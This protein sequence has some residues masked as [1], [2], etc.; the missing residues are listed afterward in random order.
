MQN[1]VISFR[2]ISL[3][4]SQPSSVVYEC[5]TAT[6]GPELQVSMWPRPHIWFSAFKRASLAP[7][8][9]VSMGLRPHLTFCACKTARL[10]TEILVSMGPSPHQSFCACKTTWLASEILV[11]LGPSPH[12]WFLLPK[13][14]L[15]DQ[16]WKSLWDSDL[17]YGFLHSKQRL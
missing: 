10:V 14:R 13:Q 1:K 7:E 8:L 6:I 4:G 11:S 15:K 16:N 17:T 2:I 3:Y 9:Q 5:K 12:L